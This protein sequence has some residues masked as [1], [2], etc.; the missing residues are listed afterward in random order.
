MA[1]KGECL[2]SVLD[3][4]AKLMVLCSIEPSVAVT[5][6]VSPS[7]TA[8]EPQTACALVDSVVKQQMLTSFSEQSGMNTTW[9][10]K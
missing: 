3:N 5:S 9:S 4:L 1:F 6:T 8:C 7:V 10:M 2:I